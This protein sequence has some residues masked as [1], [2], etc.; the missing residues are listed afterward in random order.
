LRF[1]Q[2]RCHGGPGAIADQFDGV[3]E[4]LPFSE[5]TLESFAFRQLHH[6]DMM[7]SFL[8]LLLELLDLL[9]RV[10]NVLLELGLL[11]LVHYRRT[12]PSDDSS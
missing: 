9:P 8:A 10:F 6:S 11:P 2:H 1:A 12:E 5:E 7:W 3:Q 4:L